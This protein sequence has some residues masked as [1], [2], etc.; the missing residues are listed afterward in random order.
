MRI[1]EIA[2]IEEKVPPQKYGG[3]ELVVHNVTEG[4]VEAG[5]EV[6][7]LASGDSET[8]AK[9]VPLL[10]KSIRE[11]YGPE[12]IG[13]WR[14]YLKVAALADVLNHIQGI[15]PDI[16]HNHLNWRM[17]LFAD[18]IDCPMISTM[19]GPLSSLRERETYRK[20]KNA[21]YIS[22][23]DNQRKAMPE[24]NWVKTV[25]NGI[26]LDIFDFQEKKGDYFA[27]LG[28]TSPEK[29]LEEICRMIR[30]SDHKLKI[31]AK[32][33]SVDRAYFES[34]IKPYIDGDQIEFLGEVD[35]AG[36]NELLKN[37]KAL[38]LWLNWEEPFGLV[39]PEANAC[40]TPVIVNRRGS[41]QEL[42]RDGVNG[43]LVDTLEEME[44][45]LDNVSDII[46]AACREHTRVNFS[47]EKMVKDYVEVAES[48]LG[49]A[50]G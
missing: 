4:L 3:T 5:H 43:Y 15:K 1:V 28:R 41:M 25:Y 42:V 23:S 20:H 6:L 45:K 18:L 16:V 9:L 2:A 19:H 46:P 10:P 31:A 13:E 49:A 50:K 12:E 8:K 7:L 38:L 11:M 36:K 39:V 24:L 47:K 48:L 34:H 44:A 35:H 21:N 37:A 30:K 32:V 29:G 27:F 26:D 33:D 14:D 17:L 40:G 22:I